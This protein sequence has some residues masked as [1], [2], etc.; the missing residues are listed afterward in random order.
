MGVQGDPNLVYEVPMFKYGGL[1]LGGCGAPNLG[2]WVSNFGYEVSIWL[3]EVPIWCPIWA[4][5]VPIWVYGVP[6]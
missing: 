2:I 3:Y 5:E 6:V 4:C 1:N